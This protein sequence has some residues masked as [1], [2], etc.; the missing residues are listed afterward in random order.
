[1]VIVGPTYANVPLLSKTVILHKARLASAS[2]V[3]QLSLNAWIR[4]DKGCKKNLAGGHGPTKINMALLITQP[5]CA[6][7][8][9]PPSSA[10][11]TW[12]RSRCPCCTH[13]GVTDPGGEFLGRE[14]TEDKR[15][16]GTD[17]STGQHG[18]DRFRNHR[19]V[20]E[21]AVALDYASRLQHGCELRH[22]Y[23]TCN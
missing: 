11:L 4:Q 15:V 1:M 23:I 5:L 10:W 12:E 6:D 19:H 22:L 9:G 2:N 20:D 16:D 13:L 18:N 8:C 14:S 21:H 17:A 3:G 7:Y